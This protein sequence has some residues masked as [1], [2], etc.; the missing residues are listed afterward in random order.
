MFAITIILSPG[1]TPMGVSVTYA[2]L[3]VLFGA[4]LTS[5]LE[6][7]RCS[8]NLEILSFKFRLRLLKSATTGTHLV[9]KAGFKKH[10]ITIGDR[11]VAEKGARTLLG[12]RAV[13]T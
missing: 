2:I 3:L 4:V 9:R 5:I 6:L 12:T 10:S 8:T 11:V 13:N 1:R 7:S